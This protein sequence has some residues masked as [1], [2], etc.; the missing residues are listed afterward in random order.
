MGWEG[1][2][3]LAFGG[4]CVVKEPNEECNGS[5]DVYERIDSVDPSHHDWSLHEKC[6]NSNFPKD[7]QSLFESYHLKG[8]VT[9]CVNGT[10]DYENCR[11]SSTKLVDLFILFRVEIKLQLS[12]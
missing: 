3:C 6:L 1:I 10:F 8:V 5:R 12:L 9:C 11:C 4:V 7:V 2:D